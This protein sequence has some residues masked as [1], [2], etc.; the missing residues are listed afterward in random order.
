MTNIEKDI[1]KTATTSEI[2]HKN[3]G[4][5]LKF[6]M[7]TA[8]YPLKMTFQKQKRHQSGVFPPKRHRLLI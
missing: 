8:Q 7:S 2:V 3:H 5:C 4:M 6:R 1:Q